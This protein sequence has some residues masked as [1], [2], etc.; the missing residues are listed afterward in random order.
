M[1]IVQVGTGPDTCGGAGSG[2]GCQ[3]APLRDWAGL[4]AIFLGF[5]ISG[6][7]TSFFFSFGVPYIG[8]SPLSRSSALLIC[9]KLCR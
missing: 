8:K 2:P 9:V 6:I 4:S 5:F 7:G 3:A 1:W